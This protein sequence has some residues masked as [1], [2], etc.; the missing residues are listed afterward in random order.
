[1][2][3][4][5]R[6]NKEDEMNKTHRDLPDYEGVCALLFA[7]CSA[8]SDDIAVYDED[9]QGWENKLWDERGNYVTHHIPESAN[10]G[11]SAQ[12]ALDRFGIITE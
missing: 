10:T 5:P 6:N 4:S 12:D 8:N 3:F 1:M 11:V 7:I 2:N 9:F